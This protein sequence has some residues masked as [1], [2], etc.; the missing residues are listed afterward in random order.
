M[1]TQHHM[2]IQPA[3]GLWAARLA[4]EAGGGTRASDVAPAAP[5][6]SLDTQ[7]YQQTF[8]SPILGLLE[9]EVFF[10]LPYKMGCQALAR[11]SL[12][13]STRNVARGLAGVMACV[14]RWQDTRELRS[15]MLTLGSF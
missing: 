2:K 9:T 5:A 6:V 10:N 1:K 14:G 4:G 8:P 13:V 12:E 15:P 11:S 7:W 3:T